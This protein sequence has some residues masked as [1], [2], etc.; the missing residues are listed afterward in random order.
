MIRMKDRRTERRMMCADMVEVSWTERS[1]EPSCATALLEDISSAGACL[2]LESPVPLG[3]EIH[4]RAPGQEFRGT[5]RYCVYRE[6]GYFVGVEFKASSRWS[7]K[8]F[9]PRHLLDPES[10]VQK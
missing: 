5:V 8:T 3:V 4:W 10:L 1:G 2:Q 6:I 7:K 9:E